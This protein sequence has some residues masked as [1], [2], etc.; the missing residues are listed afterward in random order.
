MGWSGS[1]H[2][3]NFVYS[4]INI[5]PIRLGRDV[6]GKMAAHPPLNQIR[7]LR[8]SPA[9]GDGG[10]GDGELTI[11]VTFLCVSPLAAL[12]ERIRADVAINN[13]LLSQVNNEITGTDGLASS[14]AAIEANL[15][16]ALRQLE[17]V[18]RVSGDF[19]D[20]NAVNQ[21]LAQIKAALRIP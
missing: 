6:L 9:R 10:I 21:S 1:L 16:Q 12:L 13:D 2:P 3:I 20:I 15:S 7:S 17:D 4:G 14:S 19:N 18:T 8:F 11:N 5:P